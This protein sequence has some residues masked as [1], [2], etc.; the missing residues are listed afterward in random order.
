MRAHFVCGVTVLNG[1]MAAVGRWAITTGVLV[2]AI[3][4]AFLLWHRYEKEPW[5]RD[6]HVRVDVVRVAPDVGGLVTSV[7]VHDNELVHRGQLLFVVDLPRYEDALHEVDARITSAQATLRQ[8]VRVKRRDVALGDLVAVES[9]EEDEARVETAR[10]AV[11]ELIAERKTA[12][13]NI[14]RTSVY[15]S[16]D[17]V[18]NNL[19]LHPGDFIAAGQ[20]ALAITDLESLRVEAYMEE[21]KLDHIRVG[22]RA[23]IRLMGTPGELQGHVISLSSGIADDQVINT[24]NQLRQVNPTFTWVRLAQ[25]I[26]IRI[27][28]DRM[29]ADTQLIA[30]RTATVMILP[31]RTR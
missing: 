21:T 29:P 22:D 23:R 6:G 11:D 13:L 1:A 9:R 2:V 30:G 12:T 31:E 4:L 19:D 28:V 25:R 10:A 24:S 15:A 14:E 5:T 20:Q 8:A 18:V 7:A 16:V 17:G 3:L 27:H 26:P